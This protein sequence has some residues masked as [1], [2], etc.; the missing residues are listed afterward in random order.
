M[1]FL[2]LIN[3]CFQLL[4]KM[5]IN[6]NKIILRQLKIL[7]FLSFLK[8]HGKRFLDEER[9]GAKEYAQERA[10]PPIPDIFALPK[11]NSHTDKQSFYCSSNK[12]SDSLFIQNIDTML[13]NHHNL[14]LSSRNAVKPD[15]ECYKSYDKSHEIVS[16][17]LEELA[18]V[19]CNQCQTL[20]IKKDIYSHTFKL[21]PGQ[22]TNCAFTFKTYHR[23]VTYFSNLRAVFF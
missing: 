10:I 8:S 9:G 11:L 4:S 17:N 2:F 1:K 19:M 23:F 15:T 13:K 12:H 18:K 22:K 21:H 3:W 20:V 5:H 6:W 16:D 7:Y 14:K